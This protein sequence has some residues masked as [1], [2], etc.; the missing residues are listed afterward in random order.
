[1]VQFQHFDLQVFARTE[2][3]EHARFAHVHAVGQQADREA[4]EAVAAGEF[5]RDV[6]NRCAR[7]LA[8]A[9]DHGFG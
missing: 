9:H 2:V 5:E 3:G 4:L 6:E 8:L 7:H 1:V